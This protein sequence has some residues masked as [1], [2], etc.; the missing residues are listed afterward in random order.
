[1]Q[2]I[3]AGVRGGGIVVLLMLALFVWR[4][5]RHAAS[6]R[7]YALF[8]LSGISYLVE[9]APG[10]ITADAAWLVPLRFLSSMSPALFQL[11]AWATFDDA[12]T[13]SRPLAW[14][15]IGAMAALTGWAM[16]VHQWLPWR[17]VEGAALLFVCVGISHVL[18]GRKADLVEG[19]DACG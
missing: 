5:A 7:Y 18:A 1:M 13:P 14:L 15:P 2:A 16:T 3:E 12:F 4:D 6:A 9:S 11:W 19:V 8:M 10:L 17:L